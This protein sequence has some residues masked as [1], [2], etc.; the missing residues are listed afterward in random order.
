M[1]TPS[2]VSGKDL[3]EKLELS[4]EGFAALRGVSRQYALRTIEEFWQ[5][6]AEITK[7]YQT[8]L[9]IG[10]DSSRVM[11]ER[12][13]KIAAQELGIT[14]AVGTDVSFSNV[15]TRPYAQLF[16]EN[17]ELW[18]FSSSPLDFEH[19]AYWEK[20]CSEFLDLED[21]MLVYFVGSTRPRYERR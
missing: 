16:A 11:A 1:S 10:S 18:V 5:N 13:K 17:K 19:T 14:I 21:R 12:L 15:S 8:L 6:E 7:F 4:H 3:L 9:A 20:L 2:S